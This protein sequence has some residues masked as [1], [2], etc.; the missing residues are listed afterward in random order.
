MAI[1]GGFMR[2][3][4][5]SR[6]VRPAEGVAEGSIAEDVTTYPDI[7]DRLVNS[8][9]QLVHLNCPDQRNNASH[10]EQQMNE[11]TQR[12]GSGQPDTPEKQEYDEQRP[13][14]AA[15]EFLNSE[16]W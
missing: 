10:E 16:L 4:T 11:A 5:E 2:P 15:S 3:R 8:A 9:R 1:R 7:S 6:S 12:E 13:Q 14:H